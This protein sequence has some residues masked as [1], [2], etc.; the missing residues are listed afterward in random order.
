MTMVGDVGLDQLLA[1]AANGRQRV[2]AGVEAIRA[3]TSLTRRPRAVARHAAT[4]ATEL[5]RIVRGTSTRAPARGDRRFGDPAWKESWLFRRL[6]QGYLSGSDLARS[7]V[8]EAGLDWAADQR[9]RLAVDNL[10]DALAPT[11]FPLTNPTVIKTTVDRG[12]AN[13][14]TGARHAL[15]DA[16]SPARLPA[17]VDTTPFSVGET[18][19]VSPG[20]V[21]RREPMYELIQYQPRTSQVRAT[22]VLMIPPMISKY[23][24]VD[25]APDRSLGADVAICGRTAERLEAAAEELRALGARV[26]TS[27]ADVRDLTAVEAAF[28]RSLDELGPAHV[29][30]CGAAGN[31]VARAESISGN[32][33]R[34]VVDIDLVGSFHTAR[35]AFAQ[36]RETRG[37]LILVSGGQASQPYAFNSALEAALEP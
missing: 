24:V 12:G 30:V 20:A 27:V 18:L 8:D 15:R 26:S 6:C 29:V 13:L 16:T 36:L 32:G 3:A 28:A 5:A 23:Y 9:L 7:L 2:A 17:N 25:L 14:V 33:F 34:S 19:A 21:V 1:E 4:F 35:T 22:P 31:F 10:I 37:S 11:N